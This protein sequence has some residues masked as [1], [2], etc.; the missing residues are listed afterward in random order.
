MDMSLMLAYGH[1]LDRDMG[2]LSPTSVSQ[3]LDE[4]KLEISQQLDEGKL[5]IKE[6]AFLQQGKR[7]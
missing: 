6:T 2:A 5:E 4:G 1:V 3:Q 7:C